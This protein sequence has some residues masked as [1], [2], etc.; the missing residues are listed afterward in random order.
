[1]VGEIRDMEESDVAKV[2]EVVCDC[3]GDRR[4][5]NRSLDARWFREK[6]RDSDSLPK[7]LI[8]DG[9]IVGTVTFEIQEEKVY[10][11][12]AF[13]KRKHQGKHLLS[14]LGVSAWMELR[15]DH[16]VFWGEARPG[17]M[18]NIGDKLGAKPVG[19]LPAKRMVKEVEPSVLYVWL[20]EGALDGRREPVIAEE[21]EPIFGEVSRLVGMEGGKAENPKNVTTG[22]SSDRYYENPELGYKEVWVSAHSPRQQKSCL[23]MGFE[24]VGYFPRWTPK[25]DRIVF[26]KFRGWPDKSEVPKTVWGLREVLVS[27]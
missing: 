19:I 17:A 23:G 11:G 22:L 3:L 2:E 10:V 13:V 4:P 8:V 15:E 14:R 6:V 16:D 9:K 24:P 20:S 7:V 18:S 25:E 26:A 21:I 1:M 5:D 27:R 12:A